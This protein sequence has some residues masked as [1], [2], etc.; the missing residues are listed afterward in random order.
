MTTA[1]SPDFGYLSPNRLSCN[2]RAMKQF[3]TVRPHCLWQSTAIF[4]I[5]APCQS[6]SFR[7]RSGTIC[8]MVSFGNIFPR[9]HAAIVSAPTSAGSSIGAGGT[10]AGMPALDTRRVSAP[11]R[12]VHSPPHGFCVTMGGRLLVRSRAGRGHRRGPPF[13]LVNDATDRIVAHRGEPC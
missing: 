10:Y 4:F 6:C 12:P 1:S 13:A 8:S 2:L 5:R 9:S 7:Q 11:G 3:P